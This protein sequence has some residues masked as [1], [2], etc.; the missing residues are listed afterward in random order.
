MNYVNF[1]PLKKIKP[2]PKDEKKNK[3]TQKL[4]ST[5][6]DFPNRPWYIKTEV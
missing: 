1:F 5:F 3:K 6:L 4:V 2:N